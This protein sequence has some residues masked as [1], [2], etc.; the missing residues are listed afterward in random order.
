[1]PGRE[2]EEPAAARR[3][4]LRS[5]GSRV[6]AAAAAWGAQSGGAREPGETAGK[7]SSGHWVG[8][9]AKRRC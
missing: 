8:I 3:S 6:G 1:M 9:V 5:G 4:S 7:V 2:M